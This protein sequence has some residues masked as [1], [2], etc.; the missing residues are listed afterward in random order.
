[1]N[2]NNLL[3]KLLFVILLC[4]TGTVSAQTQGDKLFQEGRRLQKVETVTSQKDAIKNF[5][6]AKIAYTDKSSKAKCDEQIQ[7]CNKIIARIEKE[8][9]S[10]ATAEKRRKAQEEQERAEA[11]KREKEKAEAAARAAEE[12]RRQE[13]AYAH[14]VA[15]SYYKGAL[16]SQAKKN[17]NSQRVAITL[18]QKA[19]DS[20]T[21]EKEKRD[22]DNQIA[23]CQQSIMH[24]EAQEMSQAQN[25][26]RSNDAA[27]DQAYQMAQDFQRTQTES[28][29]LSAITMYERA[30]NLYTSSDKRALCDNQI[31]A[32]N[33]TINGIKAANAARYNESV[34]S[35]YTH[36]KRSH[37][38]FNCPDEERNVAGFTMGWVQKHWAVKNTSG[39]A[40]EKMGYWDDSKNING[41]QVGIKIEPLFKYGFALNTGIFYEFYYS[42][43]AES[44][45][46][47]ESYH[48]ILMEHVLYVPLHFEYRLNFSR[49]FQLFFYGGAGIDYGLRAKIKT[50]NEY[51]SF[52]EDNGYKASGAW[53]RFNPS[54][55]FGAGICMKHVQF[56]FSMARGLKD[57][58]NDPDYTV[59]QNK[60]MVTMSLMY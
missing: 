33:R 20:F 7:V 55:E 36:R 58:S 56:D 10:E 37:K 30:R 59:K 11:A 41:M 50:D 13:E 29:Q 42:K 8:K 9:N 25:Q 1:M 39:G 46:D 60:M 6:A 38:N 57:M 26:A 3:K 31:D 19:K 5:N 22:C 4:L 14:D 28:S 43:G 54:L 49:K 2:T 17:A 44:Y 16:E 34:S 32:C 12:K 15:V 48:P 23:T 18:F 27:A 47:G 40:A 35:K 53:D 52:D 45:Y 51:L 24:L 21:S